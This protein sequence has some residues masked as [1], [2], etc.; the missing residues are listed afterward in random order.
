MKKNPID[1]TKKIIITQALCFKPNTNTK[2]LFII[3]CLSIQFYL[4][5]F[6][7][8]ILFLKFPCLTIFTLAPAKLIHNP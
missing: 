2:L 3:I 6:H 4:K 8:L 7:P 1:S 5:L